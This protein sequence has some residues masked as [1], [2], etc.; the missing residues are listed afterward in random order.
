METRAQEVM[1]QTM[2]GIM[3]RSTRI[4]KASTLDRGCST[5]SRPGIHSTFRQEPRRSRA[6]CVPRFPDQFVRRTEQPTKPKKPRT[7]RSFC[8]GL[9]PMPTV[10]SGVTQSKQVKTHL[11]LLAQV[12][13]LLMLEASTVASTS[14]VRTQGQGPQ[15]P[16]MIT[17]PPQKEAGP[18]R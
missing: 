11:Q 3:T 10:P 9:T 8:R 6:R 18:W 7:R 17:R 1:N 2:P 14:P 16:M 4:L 13:N 15:P 12:G 5:T